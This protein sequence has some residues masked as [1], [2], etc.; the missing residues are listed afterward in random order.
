LSR[1]EAAQIFLQPDDEFRATQTI[2]LRAPRR[3][4]DKELAFENVPPARYWIIVQ[5]N[6]GYVASITSGGLDLL[7]D[8]LPI[9]EGGTDPI[10]IVLRDDAAGVEG[11]VDG[12]SAQSATA[13]SSNS[14]RTYVTSIEKR[15]TSIT[16]GENSSGAWL[17][18]IPS[19]ERSG[20]LPMG[21]VS[22][23]G[24]FRLENLAPGTYRILAFDHQQE[25]LDYRNPEAMRAFE[26]K[27]PIVRLAPNQT[28]HI[29]L[30]LIHTAD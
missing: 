13:R 3:N 19:P 7:R 12:M 10:E 17:Y 21:G 20:A 29:H 1:T 22:P 27:G 11:T 4:N 26:D 14:S 28:E 24:S 23:D 2:G 30:T 5:P 15:G 16:I 6:Y 8:P 18:A 9:G 25:H